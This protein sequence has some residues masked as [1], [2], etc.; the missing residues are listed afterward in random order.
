MTARGLVLAWAVAMLGALALLWPL[1]RLG[2]PARLPAE[3][4]GGAPV[5]FVGSSLIKAAVPSRPVPGG[6]LGDGRPHRRLARGGITEARALQ[7]TADAL[8]QG[9]DLV[10]LEVNPFA[11]DFAREAQIHAARAAAGPDLGLP[12]LTERVEAGLARLSGK[13]LEPPEGDRPLDKTI[14]AVPD[15]IALHYPVTLRPPREAAALQAVAEQARAAGIPLVLVA[16]PRSG[17]ARA[18]MG[19]AAAGALSRH[20]AALAAALD[21]P[22]FAPGP[23]WPDALF[24]DHAHMNAAGQTRFLAELQD[25]ARAQ[26]LVAEAAAS[27]ALPPAAAP[28]PA[29]GGAP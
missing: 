10:F 9:P 11:L 25:W 4:L 8:A 28:R 29:A 22:L 15:A 7:F 26:G 5:V 24:Y 14:A 1:A 23:V 27:P 17:A 3:D 21:L 16:P 6:V 20:L 18:A 13:R 2:D 19:D 12:L